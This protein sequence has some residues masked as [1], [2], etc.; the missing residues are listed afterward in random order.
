MS[1]NRRDFIKLGVAASTLLAAGVAP[2][3]AA[4]SDA[5]AKKQS[6][7]FDSVKIGSLMLKSRMFRAAMAD[8]R[9]DVNGNPT[10]SLLGMYG[11]D[12]AGGV[13]MV[14]T[15]GISVLKEDAPGTVF[16][17][18]SEASQIPLY[19]GAT[20]SAHKNGAKI[21]AQLVI[22]ATP[23]G[24]FGVNNITREDIR[25][26]VNAY[27]QTALFAR[28]AG[29]DAIEFHY[30]HGYLGSQMWS[31]YVNK[32]TDEYGGSAEN[33]ARFA[34]EALEAVRKALGKDFPLIAKI[35]SDEYSVV[36]EGS[37]QEETNYYVQGLVDRGI[38][39]VEISGNDWGNRFARHILSK[40]DQ[41]YYSRAARNIAKSVNVPMILTGGIRNVEMM[42]EALKYNSK[43]VAFGMARTILCEPDLPNKWQQNTSYKPKC[44]SCH[45][46]L[47]DPEQMRGKYINTSDPVARMN[48]RA[49]CAFNRTRA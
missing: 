43:L 17:S 4:G 24:Q 25:R 34:F 45:W 28:D 13:A 31:H 8:R 11:E 5:A 3:I 14:I 38:D 7:I 35:N 39:A 6:P 42:E 20:D 29:Y 33:R 16:P 49:T 41:N 15:G 40:E 18:F 2:S 47:D 37:S 48:Y 27:A 30:A 10:P 9:Y 21:C 44:I 46:C 12:A 26:G 36:R 1:T 23:N 32:R 19:R 22:V